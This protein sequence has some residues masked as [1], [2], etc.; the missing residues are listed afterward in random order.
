MEQI[1][2]IGVGVIT[3]TLCLLVGILIERIR[4]LK[5]EKA[6]N[7]AERE[8]EN[9]TIKT[10]IKAI[11]L[12]NLKTSHEF[13]CEQGYCSLSSKE[14]VTELYK[15]YADLGG[16]GLGTHMYEDIVDLPSQKQ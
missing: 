1:I 7:K 9:S 2:S 8:K 11:L 12:N 13:Y 6:E 14:E 10:A 3:S 5:K 4:S 15:C 16:N